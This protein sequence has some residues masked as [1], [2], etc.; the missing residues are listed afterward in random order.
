M[1]FDSI[2]GYSTGVNDLIGPVGRSHAVGATTVHFGDVMSACE[3]FIRGSEQVVGAVAWVRSPRLVRA[4][5][6]RPTALIVTKEFALRKDWSKERSALTPLRGG[7]VGFSRSKEPV[8]VIGD[9]SRGAF[10]GLM[11]HKFLIRLRKGKPVAVWTGSFN[12]TS[13]AAGNFENAVEIDEPQVAAVYFAEFA[14]LWHVAE[15]LDFKS[16]T[17]VGLHRGGT[18]TA[19]RRTATAATPL[20]RVT[21]RKPA[22]VKRRPVAKKRAP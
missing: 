4:L 17:P 6:E 18:S 5:A 7:V 11:H 16:S 13:G 19:R 21:P 22:P 1:T 2:W 14:R 12:L 9:C 15:P 8:R 20:K 3:A 10:T